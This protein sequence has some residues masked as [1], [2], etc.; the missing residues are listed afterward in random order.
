MERFA[1]ATEICRAQLA[2]D[3]HQAFYQNLLGV[4]FISKKD[5]AAAEKALDQAVALQPEWPVPY[6]NLAQLSLIQGKTKEA[7]ANFEAAIEANP[8]NTAASL[9]LGKIYEQQKLYDQAMAVYGKALEAQPNLWAAANNLAFLIAE[10]SNDPKDLERAL[11][12]GL[13]ANDLRPGDPLVQDTLAWIYFKQGNLQ[14]ARQLLTD[15]IA[16][17]PDNP[18]LNYHLGAVLAQSGS[19]LEAREKLTAALA[20]NE[21]F[22]GREEAEKLLAE[23]RSKE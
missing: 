17:S 18:V 4:V 13:K 20:A 9:A 23:L 5:Y 22:Q 8:G 15:A 16:E 6:N 14:Q 1:E 19:L 21:L 12:L 7:A 2:R 3:P 10:S 11:A